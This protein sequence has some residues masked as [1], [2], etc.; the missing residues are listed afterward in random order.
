MAV[1]LLAQVGIPEPESCMKRYPHELS[2][3]QRQRI[4]I[5]MAMS[6]DAKLLI[7]DEPTTALD[8]TI[9][10]Q[11]LELMK[12]IKEERH[13]S[14]LMITHDLGVVAELCDRVIVMYCGKI[15]ESGTVKQIFSQPSHPYT[16]ALL[17]SIP[18][19]E[20]KGG[21][22]S[23]IEGV[24]PSITALPDG[25]RFHPRCQFACDT[26]RS[27]LPEMKVV[28]PKHQVAC[29]LAERIQQ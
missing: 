4:M 11:I 5:A 17:A 16:K 25:C 20:R 13:N 1:S 21:R 9:Q 8:M 28:A 19:L 2:G 22:L 10:A 3:G 6:C 26:C 14:I 27:V 15:V 12:K 23:S 24:V 18:S 7:A 29:H